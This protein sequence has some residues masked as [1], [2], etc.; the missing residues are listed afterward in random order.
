MSALQ[1]NSK[2]YQIKIF[3]IPELNAKHE[4]GYLMADVKDKYWKWRMVVSNGSTEEEV[5]V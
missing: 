4:Q 3:P 2:S 5:L 1:D